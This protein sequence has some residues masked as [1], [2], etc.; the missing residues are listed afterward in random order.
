MSSQTSLHSLLLGTVT[1]EFVIRYTNTEW[2][3]VI[4]QIN[5]AKRL[6]ARYYTAKYWSIT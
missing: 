1:E 5:L 6:S 4:V 2:K 3:F